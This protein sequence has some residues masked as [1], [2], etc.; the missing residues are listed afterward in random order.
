MNIFQRFFN[1]NHALFWRD[2]SKPEPEITKPKSDPDYVKFIERL[3]IKDFKYDYDED[4]WSRTWTTN[5]GQECALEVYQWDRH[6]ERWVAKMINGDGEL[7]YEHNV[8]DLT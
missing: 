8:E 4:W 5:K 1:L 6:N 3:T 7:F 2:E